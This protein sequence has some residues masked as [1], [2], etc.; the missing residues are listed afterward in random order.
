MRIC[1]LA[2]A[3]LMACQGVDAESK[4]TPKPTTKAKKPM[5]PLKLEWSMKVDGKILRIDYKVTNTSKAPILL[6]EK[7]IWDGKPNPDLIIVR[8]DTEPKTIAFTRALVTTNEKMMHTPMPTGV[9]IAPG[10]TV[11]GYSLS[12]WPPF[13][14]H[15]FSKVDALVPGA[16]HAVLEIGYVDDPDA[17]LAGSPGNGG[18]HV[19]SKMGAQKLLRSER[20]PLPQ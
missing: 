3:T 2:I 4:A 20:V 11:S 10:D 14:W 16:T 13:A 17:K 18:F 7:L 19:I 9:A 6:V 5:T 8:N 12:A 15:N 1:I